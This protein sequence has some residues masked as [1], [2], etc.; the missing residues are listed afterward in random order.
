MQPDDGI[1][2]AREVVQGISPIS[3]RGTS[4][5]RFLA[6]W[7]LRGGLLATASAGRVSPAPSIRRNRD[8]KFA[9]GWSGGESSTCE[10]SLL[11]DPTLFHRR[12]HGEDRSRRRQEGRVESLRRHPKFSRG[13]DNARVPSVRWYPV[14]TGVDGSFA[15]SSCVSAIATLPAAEV[16]ST[17]ARNAMR[18]RPDV[19]R[20][21]VREAHAPPGWDVM[22][23][24]GLDT[25]GTCELHVIRGR[26]DRA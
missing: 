2:R 8:L 5:A 4:R 13:R 23:R 6:P 14:A 25:A 1:E 10:R 15:R 19:A 9:R 26:S 24:N 22:R 17:D 18:T 21:I 3:C 12:F 20:A 16:P 7:L 11:L